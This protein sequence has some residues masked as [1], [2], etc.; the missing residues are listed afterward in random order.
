MDYSLHLKNCGRGKFKVAK[1]LNRTSKLVHQIWDE[2][3]T[4]IVI[5]NNIII[6]TT[7]EATQ[8]N[9]EVLSVIRAPKKQG[10]ETTIGE[11]RE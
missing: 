10:K 9:V 6:V 7:F 1:F 11:K 5:E 3:V 2:M 8:I 4:V